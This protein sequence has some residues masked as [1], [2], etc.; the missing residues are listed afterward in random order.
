MSVVTP[1]LVCFTFSGPNVM[2]HPDPLAMQQ[3]PLKGDKVSYRGCVYYV[4]NISYDMDHRAINI[5][6]ERMRRR[7]T[8]KNKQKARKEAKQE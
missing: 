6:C 7:Y 8:N 3:H 1:F 2:E 4:T 5:L